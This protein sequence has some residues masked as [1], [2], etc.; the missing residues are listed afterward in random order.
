MILGSDGQPIERKDCTVEVNGINVVGKAFSQSYVDWNLP[1][2]EGRMIQ[3][4]KENGGRMH[5]S[6]FLREYQRRYE[7]G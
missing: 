1:L 4:L 2:F 7:N 3:I 6:E 5:I